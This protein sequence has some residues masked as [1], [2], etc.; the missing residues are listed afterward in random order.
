METN[1][2]CDDVKRRGEEGGFGLEPIRC[3]KSGSKLVE[4][5]GI[6]P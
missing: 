6:K 1:S 3:W 2:Y 5:A 4:S